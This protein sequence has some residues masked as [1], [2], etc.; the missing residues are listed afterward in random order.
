MSDD[1]A[2]NM[3]TAGALAPARTGSIGEDLLHL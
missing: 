3:I 1:T 2:S